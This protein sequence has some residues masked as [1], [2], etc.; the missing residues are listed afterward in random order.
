MKTIFSKAGGLFLLFGI[1]L[2]IVSCE[3]NEPLQQKQSEQTVYYDVPSLSNSSW[4]SGDSRY[5]FFTE[6]NQLYLCYSCNSLEPTSFARLDFVSSESADRAVSVLNKTVYKAQLIWIKDIER[7]G[8]EYNCTFTYNGTSLNCQSDLFSFAGAAK[9]DGVTPTVSLSD[10]PSIE[11]VYLSN[12][13]GSYSL[14]NGYTLDIGAKINIAADTNHYWFANVAQ[15]VNLSQTDDA[16][17]YQILLVHSS[18]KNASGSID[19]GITGSE[20]FLSEQGL[21]WTVMHIKNIANTNWQVLW[22]PDWFSSPSQA[23]QA[24][25]TESDL[26][27]GEFT[28]PQSSKITYKYN[29][30]FGNP[31]KGNDGYYTVEKGEAIHCVTFTLDLPSQKTWKE[32]YT[33]NNIESKISLG[34]GKT[35]DYW[36]Y[37]TN[38]ITGIEDSYVYKLSDSYIPSLYEYDFYLA[39]KDEIAAGDVYINPGVFYRAASGL[40]NIESDS[41]TWNYKKYTILDGAQWSEAGKSTT[42]P[43]LPL[44]YCYLVTDGTANYYCLVE[45]YVNNGFAYNHFRTPKITED[46]ICKTEKDFTLFNSYK[47]TLNKYENSTLP[48]LYFSRTSFWQGMGTPY[49]QGDE[50]KDDSGYCYFIL[51]DDKTITW[52][53]YPVVE[54]EENGEEYRERQEYSLIKGDDGLWILAEVVSDADSQ[55]YNTTMLSMMD[56]VDGLELVFEGDTISVDYKGYMQIKEWYTYKSDE[57]QTLQ[58][59]Q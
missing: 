56:Y 30:Y 55:D 57:P 16:P 59:I 48:P 37:S 25:K 9:Y 54:D 23:F 45:Y 8:E 17:D 6:D 15:V 12:L 24:Y 35:A 11:T 53:T 22:S 51:K 7:I 21:F 2:G 33:E 10:I 28:G 43:K 32:I 58:I 31:V 36:W 41:I 34:N 38:S 39:T 49:A 13:S 3:Q 50:Q 19:P 42:D 18:Q 44:Q 29:F 4:F 27:S 26:V 52:V 14:S 47:K 5:D 46:T 20:Q 40:L 1:L